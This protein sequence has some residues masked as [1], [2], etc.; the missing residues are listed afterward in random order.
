MAERAGE[1]ISG[2]SVREW[3]AKSRP[4]YENLTKVVQ[5]LLESLLRNSAIDYLSITG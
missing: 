5:G 4:T 1:G 3:Y 2:E